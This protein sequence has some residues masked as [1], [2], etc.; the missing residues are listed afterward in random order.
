MKAI[1][2]LKQRLCKLFNVITVV[3]SRKQKQAE[4]DALSFEERIRRTAYKRKCKKEAW[5][6]YFEATANACKEPSVLYE[7]HQKGDSK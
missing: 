5:E 4:W 3:E 2:Y 1:G 6:G 7:I